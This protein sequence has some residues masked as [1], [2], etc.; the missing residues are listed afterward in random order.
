ME[1]KWGHDANDTRKTE[2]VINDSDN[3]Q[4]CIEKLIANK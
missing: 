4:D 3:P 1:S 2:M